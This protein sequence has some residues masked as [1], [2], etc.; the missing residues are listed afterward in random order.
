MTPWKIVKN[1][2]GP[3]I[4]LIGLGG[5]VWWKTQLKN[6]HA[7]VPLSHEFEMLVSAS[8]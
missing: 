8:D 1:E 2:N 6:S 4:S 3:R 5:V 7:T